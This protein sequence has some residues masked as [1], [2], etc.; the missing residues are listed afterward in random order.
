MKCP[1]CHGT[2]INYDKE[3]IEECDECEGC[4]VIRPVTNEEWLCNLSTE[5]KA[6]FLNYVTTACYHCG[7]FD[8]NE[9][10]PFGRCVDGEADFEMWLKEKHNE[11]L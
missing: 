10:C 9:K 5:E 7:M 4:G 3:F 6:S 1:Y 8:D 2:G 11:L